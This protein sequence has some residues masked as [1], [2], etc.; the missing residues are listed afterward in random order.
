MSAESSNPIDARIDEVRAQFELLDH[1][2]YLNSA[3]QT[4]PGRYWLRAARRF[5]DLVEAGRMEDTPCADLATHP[6]LTAAWSES[7]ERSA[8]FI[9]AH[10]DEVTN[11][12]RPTMI[13]NLVFYN[14]LEW[15]PGDNVVCTDLSYPGYV[16]ILQ[17]IR[18]RYGVELRVVRHVDG[19]VPLELLD[20]AVDER[21]R[22]VVVDR[23]A[24]FSGFTFDMAEVCRLAHARGALVL[25]DAFQALGAIAIDVRADGVDML[26][27]GAYKWACG[28]EGAGLFYIR[29]EL[30]ERIDPRFRN[31]VWADFPGAIPFVEPGHDNVESWDYPPVRTANRFSQ[32][33]VIGPALFGWIATMKFYEQLG[34][35]NV[36][37]RVRRLG[38][39][40]IERLREVGC[41]IKTPEDPARRHGLVVYTTGAIERDREF[42]A[43]CAAPGRC[44]RPIKL[45]L[46]AQA[47]IGNLRIATHFFNTTEDIDALVA[48]HRTMS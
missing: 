18:R 16:Y 26:M 15:E 46:R 10:P 27:A 31:Y 24:A 25:D 42:F 12:Y 11:A 38:S 32:D 4:I 20:A 7:I 43:R 17:D 8:R 30:V 48:L 34:I 3:D 9:N 22:V 1:W 21:T 36:E 29:K 5:Y 35:A 39:Y 33:T 23:T 28:P 44:E 2:V 6:F 19:A 45:S 47:G 41:Q 40:A 14:M 37:E 13:A